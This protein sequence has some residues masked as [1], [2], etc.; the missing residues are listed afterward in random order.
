MEDLPS[1]NS[2]ASGMSGTLVSPGY[3]DMKDLRFGPELGHVLGQ[4]SPP[5][6]GHDH[7]GENQVHG[8]GVALQQFQCVMTILGLE[9]S[10]A[11]GFEHLTGQAANVRI[12]FD[13]HRRP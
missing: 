4:L 9:D 11:I 1:K 12:V 7:M 13:D 6:P 2:P 10:I 5:D 3:P 8:G